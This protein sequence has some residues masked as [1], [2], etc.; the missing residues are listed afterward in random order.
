MGSA[1]VLKRLGTLAG[2]LEP[3]PRVQHLF[4]GKKTRLLPDGL[5][6]PRADYAGN[7]PGSAEVEKRKKGVH[8]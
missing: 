4:S 6:N 3:R 2:K 5:L 7:D 1:K 8:V